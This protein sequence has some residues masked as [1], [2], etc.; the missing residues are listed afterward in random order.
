M[1][2]KVERLVVPALLEY[3]AITG[4]NQPREGGGRA[5]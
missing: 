2:Q 1:I 3:D 5:R 4:L